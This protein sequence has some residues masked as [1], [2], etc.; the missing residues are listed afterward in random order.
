MLCLGFGLCGIAALLADQREFIATQA[1]QESVA[2]S[3]LNPAADLLQQTVAGHVSKDVID[4]LE[5]VK[6]DAE[7]GECLSGRFRAAQLLV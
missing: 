1:R 6:V 5:A 7:Q 2:Q 4:L 3:V